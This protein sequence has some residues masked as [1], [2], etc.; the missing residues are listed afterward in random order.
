MMAEM[1]R[2]LVH[3]HVLDTPVTGMWSVQAAHSISVH[4]YARVNKKMR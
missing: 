2:F 1:R 4:T 3:P